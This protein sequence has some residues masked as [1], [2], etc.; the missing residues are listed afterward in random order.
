MFWAD[1]PIH[2][3]AGRDGLPLGNSFSPPRKQ[4]VTQDVHDWME[5]AFKVKGV[6]V[7][8]YKFDFLALFRAT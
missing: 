4:V 3:P 7:K 1:L 5:L 8:A 2:C 6:F